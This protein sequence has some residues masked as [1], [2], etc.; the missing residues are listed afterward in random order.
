MTTYILSTLTT[1]AFKSNLKVFTNDV[2]YLY[3]PQKLSQIKELQNDEEKIL[4][5]DPDFVDWNVENSE[6]KSVKNLKAVLT[7]STSFGWVEQDYLNENNIP[8][9]NV[10]D[11]CTQS[12][13]EWAVMMTLN[14]A[15]KVPML[16]KNDF[17]IDYEKYCGS[18]LKGKTA[19]IIGM[20]N[21]GAA[22][23][24]R[25]KGLGLNVIYWSKSSKTAHGEFTDLDTLF[26]SADFIFP[27]LADN[28]ETRKILT[29]A[30]LKSMKKTA[31]FI[32]ITHHFYNH[33][34]L[35]EMVENQNLGGY[36]FEDSTA[37]FTDFKGNIWVVP[38]YAWCTIESSE[39]NESKLINNIKDVLA[40]NF[41]QRVN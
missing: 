30:H 16:I 31:I 9:I 10:K 25:L 19:G 13:A 33:D 27:A 35:I 3:V 26:A 40:G 1:E 32:S 15:R 18:Q 12:V 11:W 4:V 41:S 2:I 6:L 38:E 21:I 23:A 14:L 20:G 5:I 36:G 34:L 39:E 24:E 22:L 29:D 28:K 8:L 17:P 37:K 7:Q